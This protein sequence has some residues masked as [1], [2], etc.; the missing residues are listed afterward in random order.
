MKLKLLNRISLRALMFFFFLPKSLTL[1]LPFHPFFT[2]IQVFGFSLEEE[3]MEAI[4]KLHDGRH[5]CW[6]P[7]NVE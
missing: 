1:P 4:N 6:D 3:D 5:L 7:A 2:L